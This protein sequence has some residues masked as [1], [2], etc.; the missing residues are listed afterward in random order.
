MV[1]SQIQLIIHMSKFGSPR[2]KFCPSIVPLP[3]NFADQVLELEIQVETQESIEAFKSLMELYSKAIEYYNSIG[4]AKYKYYQERMISFIQKQDSILQ[5]HASKTASTT[6]SPEKVPTSRHSVSTTS[7]LLFHEPP[8][9]VAPEV[10]RPTEL[11]Q[12]RAADKV[13]KQ[14]EQES[15]V[16]IKHAQQNIKSQNDNLEQRVISRKRGLTRYRSISPETPSCCESTFSFCSPEASRLD[17]PER[18]SCE[19]ESDKSGGFAKPN[20]SV[21]FDKGLEEIMEKYITEKIKESGRISK[22]YKEQIEEIK[23]IGGSSEIINQIV[24]EMERN[25]ENELKDLENSLEFKRKQE[26]DSLRK[27]MGLSS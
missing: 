5:A 17:I 25:R 16:S 11:A 7:K 14:H 12:R 6:T 9:E 22:M 10:H 27:K 1:F 20:I 21:I 26:I 13:M 19:G 24:K 8:F 4:D 15:H 2:V 18:E 23:S 3:S